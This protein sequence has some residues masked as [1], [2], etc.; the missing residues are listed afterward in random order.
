MDLEDEG[1]KIID[2]IC[3]W[4][5]LLGFGNP[6]IDSGWN[7]NDQRCEQQLQRI[8]SLDLSL[9]NTFSSHQGTTSLSLND[10]MIINFDIEFESAYLEQRIIRVLDD[11]ILE[12]QN[13][14]LRD[15]K[16]GYPGIRGVLT[17]GHRYN[18]TDVESTVRVIDGKTT[19][20]HPKDFQ[21]N[22]AFSKAYII[23]SSGSKS[24]VSGNRLYIDKFLLDSIE[25]IITKRQNQFR[26]EKDLSDQNDFKL[27]SIYNNETLLLKL[28]FDQVAVDYN[29]KGI[30]TI[31]YKFVKRQSKQDEDARDAAF[32]AAQRYRQAEIDEFEAEN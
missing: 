20:Y 4:Y 21:M 19:S 23:E 8:K 28:V 26:I 24:G 5:D 29:Y 32:I 2:C 3:A 10:G 11:L 18:Y 7:L 14:N 17:F 22:T 6:L 27:Y 12:Y 25:S 30:N 16:A 9:V 1:F 15:G 31:L 13:L